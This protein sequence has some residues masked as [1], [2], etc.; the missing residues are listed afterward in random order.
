MVG[1]VQAVASMVPSNSAS[2]MKR[3]YRS[4]S[5]NWSTASLAE[6]FDGAFDFYANVRAFGLAA[7]PQADMLLFQFGVYNWGHG[8][9]F[10]VDLTRQ[11]IIAGAEDDDALS[12]LR[13]TAYYQPTPRFRGVGANDRW[14]EK[15]ADLGNFKSFVLSSEGYL[16]ALEETPI[17]RA[18][19]WSP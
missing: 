8:E 1:R 2:A 18:I 17:R 11:F 14:C 5:I 15:R 12:Q 4:R 7:A 13:C 9:Y 6:L 19:E 3:F 16:V 10:E